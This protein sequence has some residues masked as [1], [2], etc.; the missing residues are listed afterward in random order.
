MNQ[1]IFFAYNGKMKITLEEV[2]VFLAVV[3]TGSLTA[4]AEH[5]QQPVSTTSRLLARLE[6]K[7][8]VTLLR[9]TT[10]RLDLTDEGIGFVSDARDIM[11]SVSVAEDRLMERSGRLSGPLYIDASS[12]FMLHV[13][14]P[15]MPGYR[16]MHPEVD[17][18]M[19][20]DEGFIDLIERR[21]DLAIRIGEL[22]DSTLHSRLLG[23]TRIK[24]Y[25]SADYLRQR[26]VPTD[27]SDLA[28][29]ELLGFSTSGELNSWPLQNGSQAMLKIKPT[30]QSSNGEMLY[31]LARQGMGIAKISEFMVG[32]DVALRNLVEVLPNQTTPYIKPIN[33]V[34]YMHS[35]VSGRIASMVRYLM[36]AMN[37]PEFIWSERLATPSAHP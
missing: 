4:A 9:R 23:H 21:V 13:L 12:S 35:A 19:S 30:V 10:R 27:I 17:L 8:Q 7:L 24:L 16:E 36:A 3:D 29:H 15:L 18:V 34:Y 20:A 22:K 28:H 25:A 37:R 14:A 26:G 11:K 1:E 2:E 31:Q 32:N 6:E 33:A 5:L